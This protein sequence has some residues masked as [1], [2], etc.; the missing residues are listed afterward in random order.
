MQEKKYSFFSDVWRQISSDNRSG[1]VTNYL[2]G[3]NPFLS[4]KNFSVNDDNS[5]QKESLSMWGR[6]FISWKRSPKKILL[7]S[8]A[9][10]HLEQELK[11]YKEGKNPKISWISGIGAY[12]ARRNFHISS[13]VF[14]FDGTAPDEALKDMKKIS[15]W[16]IPVKMIASAPSMLLYGI[17]EG[18][19][20][21]DK[22]AEKKI[23]NP[24]IK[25]VTK[26]FINA[27][28]LPFTATAVVY[29]A[30]TV[31]LVMGAESTI[32]AV[33]E[34]PSRL[35]SFLKRSAPE[36]QLPQKSGNNVPA[37]EKQASRLPLT[38]EPVI[39]KEHKST[40]SKL[41]RTQVGKIGDTMR[42]NSDTRAR[43][44]STYENPRR[45]SQPIGKSRLSLD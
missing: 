27:V 11:K 24:I 17:C 36:S 15:K 14:G 30:A 33:A 40:I 3:V 38:T 45:M 35:A 44:Q 12:V 13:A 5:K 6:V 8:I 29:T 19:N 37:I 41:L 10:S 25:N 21:L 18:L 34:I 39:H 9:S 16:K 23:P 1:Y 2:L 22:L 28:A 42:R 32:K 31:G 20:E 4:Q 43:V 7:T 26:V